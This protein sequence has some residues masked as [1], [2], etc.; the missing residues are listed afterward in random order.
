[1]AAAYCA[2][3]RDPFTGCGPQPAIAEDAEGPSA[4]ERPAPYA[5][6]QPLPVSCSCGWKRRL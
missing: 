6:T 3:S 5:R 4:V 1:M 2:A